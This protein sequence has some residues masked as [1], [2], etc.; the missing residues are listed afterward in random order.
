MILWQRNSG[1]ATCVPTGGFGASSGKQS[2]EWHWWHWVGSKWCAYTGRGWVNTKM[3]TFASSGRLVEHLSDPLEWD[4]DMHKTHWYWSF[5]IL[6][7]FFTYFRG[8]PR[9]EE[10]PTNRKLI[11]GK[12]KT[13]IKPPL[14]Q[15]S[16][17]EKCWCSGSLRTDHH[18]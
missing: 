1:D 16:G 17:H 12:L 11:W 13:L 8:Q 10:P 7:F 6:C 5:M 15:I 4:K 9:I 3:T 14:V 2:E 18:L